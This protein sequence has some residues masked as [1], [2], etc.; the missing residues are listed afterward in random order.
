MLSKI[1][2]NASR[3]W[4]NIGLRLF[5][6]YPI[7]LLILIT[8]VFYIFNSRVGDIK[9]NLRDY[10]NQVQNV[11][12]NK[13]FE[14]KKEFEIYT[15]HANAHDY[16]LENN[17]DVALAQQLFDENFKAY[18]F[19]DEN[20]NVLHKKV[21]D[22]AYALDTFGG[23]WIFETTEKK[24]FI[25]SKFI[26][27]SGHAKAIFVSYYIGHKQRVVAEVNLAKLSGEI[28]ALSNPHQHATY[29]FDIDG[30]IIQTIVPNIIENNMIGSKIDTKEVD[31][32]FTKDGL[33]ELSYIKMQA[34]LATYNE[35][36][37]VFVLVYTPRMQAIGLEMLFFGLALFLFFIYTITLIG[38]IRFAKRYVKKPI[39]EINKCIA[40]QNFKQDEKFLTEFQTVFDKLKELYDKSKEQEIRLVDYKKRYGY[41][42]EQS[43]LIVLI[44]DAYDGQIVDVSQQA[45][46]FYGY[47]HDEFIKLNCKDIFLST[48]EEVIFDVRR[49]MEDKHSS[50]TAQHILKNGEVRDMSVRN[51]AVSANDKEYIFTIA[52]DITEQN[53]AKQNQRVVAEYYS[54]FSEVIMLGE[55]DDIL[56]ISYS[57]QNI[58]KLLG[59][60]H[61]DVMGG[62]VNLKEYIFEADRLGFIN[63]L[64]LA[65]RFFTVAKGAKDLLNFVI[66]LKTPLFTGI[67]YKIGV[68][69]FKDADGK[70]DA[71]AY[72]ISEYAEQKQ[73]IDKFENEQKTNKN[74][75]WASDT[76]PFEYDPSE[77]VIKTSSEF[78]EI[79]GV[80][81]LAIV[82]IDQV[83]MRKIVGEKFINFD[84]FFADICVEEGVYIGEIKTKDINK[85]A[86]WLSIRARQ[87]TLSKDGVNKKI[88][89]V[90]RNI[91][92]QKISQ[93]YQELAS[94]LFSYS[95][96][97]IAIFDKEWKFIDV[98]EN[99]CNEMG[100]EYDEIL[101]SSIHILNSRFTS[102]QEY[103]NILSSTQSSGVWQGRIWIKNKKGD[104]KFI[105]INLSEVSDKDD[106]VSYY[107]G[108]FSEIGEIR[109]TQEYLDH[110]AY[111]D[112][113]TKLPNRY[114]F[115]QKLSHAIA[116][117]DHAKQVA[118][119]YLN[120]DGF[121]AIND[122]YGYQAGDKFLTEISSKIDVLFEDRDM[123]ARI[124][125]DEFVAI[126]LHE[127]VGEIYEMA[128]NI[129]RI[130]CGTIYHEG[131]KLFA[132][133]SIGISINDAMKNI[134]AENMIEQAGWAM[135]K[136]KLSGK[137]RYYVFDPKKDKNLKDQYADNYKI[138]TA[139]ENEQIFIEY[140]PEIDLKTN[141]VVSFEA[142]IRWEHN[143]NIVYPNEFLPLI[144]QQSVIEDIAIFAIK[145]AL[146][147]QAAWQKSGKSANVCVNISIIELCSDSF[148][149]KFKELVLR[150]SDVN[151][152]SLFIEII[153]ANNV[154]DLVQS[155]KILQRYKSFGVSFVLDDFASKTSSFEALE[156]LPIDKIKVDKNICTYMFFNKKAFSTVHIIKNV[157][158][159][160]EKA[161]T[162]KNLQDASTLK[163][164]SGLGFRNFQGNFFARPMRLEDVLKYEFKGISGFDPS[165]S[166]DDEMFNK[167]AECIALKEYAQNIISTLSTRHILDD[168]EIFVGLKNEILPK[169][170]EFSSSEYTNIVNNL[171]EAFAT[172][173]KMRTLSLARAANIMC[174]EIL[175]IDGKESIL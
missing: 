83:R 107:I 77:Q 126:I 19:I 145:S 27:S 36:L 10:N 143:G 171:K 80:D 102:S 93:G 51:S 84:T 157:A 130:A 148:Y 89:G 100:Y 96:D 69:F 158:D 72:H 140:Q 155:S 71:V 141:E 7:V 13:I 116:Q 28:L 110:I 46:E 136:A 58:E 106:V 151:L 15:R 127:N 54:A 124:G 172:S 115:N 2:K 21:T 44:Y 153:D 161:P 18:Y 35:N 45:C 33:V 31:R 56:Q 30:N 4:F 53:F 132:S 85:K 117:Q 112:P 49:C 14:I 173:D 162:I 52:T 129:L 57:T 16:N 109:T 38:N 175:N 163:I 61:S 103:A 131:K 160:F 166:I 108:V 150:N 94:R 23:K 8:L 138:L 168:S 11:I 159:M 149:M 113:L 105:L 137:N 134:S 81:G 119:A 65:R 75:I 59:I 152:N 135:Y 64:E 73:L 60:K 3:L 66:R 142:L 98:N 25:I 24:P 111:H 156:L 32:Y 92:D 123:F 90:F 39:D 99:F 22:S 154:T 48:F 78:G 147:A 74:L 169:L 104:D 120:F 68:K 139:L 50:F 164:L 29:I 146:K 174:A 167:L 41:I 63:E 128:E 9:F 42:F 114:L 95:K 55:K 34:N 67:Y 62:N 20:A 86:I 88:E 43:P 118:L 82:S 125:G 6:T 122:T 144:Q 47:S 170:N 1:F 70:F 101:G 121:K 37:G 26:S 165:Y 97:S 12:D 17:I 5:M 79:L 133:A 91:T 40:E 87:T 76:I